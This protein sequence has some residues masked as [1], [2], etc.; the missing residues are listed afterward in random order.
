MVV[1]AA[2]LPQRGGRARTP[3]PI[4]RDHL[5]GALTLNETR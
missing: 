1:M 3:D 2:S 5:G 4:G